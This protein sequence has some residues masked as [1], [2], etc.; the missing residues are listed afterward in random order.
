MVVGTP[1]SLQI[2]GLISI[3]KACRTRYQIDKFLTK[4]KPSYEAESFYFDWLMMG[5]VSGVTNVFFRGFSINPETIKLSEHNGQYLPKDMESGHVFMHDFGF[6]GWETDY[7]IALNRLQENMADSV[8]KYR[9]L[10]QKTEA[11][12]KSETSVA[13]VYQGSAS[14]E[15]WEKL[16]RT[17][18]DRYKKAIP[19]VNAI[20]LD[21]TA[22]LAEGILTIFTDDSH[23]PKNGTANQWEGW[24][25]K[26][27][28]AFNS[29]KCFGIQ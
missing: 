3:G 27:Y 29:L 12:L 15:A 8:K 2:D 20:E 9:Y 18:F 19:I 25:E 23:S 6:R 1:N 4:I 24:D 5:G 16:L 13:L 22:T 17:L 14:E 26:W 7:Q 21:Q 11:L 28:S 10:G